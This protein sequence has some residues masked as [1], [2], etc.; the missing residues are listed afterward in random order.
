MMAHLEAG[1]EASAR[2]AAETA[3]ALLAFHEE[4]GEERNATIDELV[5]Y[6][7][8]RVPGAPLALPTLE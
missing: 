6:W 4:L 2:W 8:S 5:R 1:D 3:I 7:A